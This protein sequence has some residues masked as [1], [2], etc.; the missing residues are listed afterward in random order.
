MKITWAHKKDA[1]WSTN[2]TFLYFSCHLWVFFIE[3]LSGIFH[4]ISEVFLQ[5]PY[6][7]Y[8]SLTS[9]CL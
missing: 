5:H 7:V 6:F 9:P 8:I 2:L 4:I 3:I 1:Y